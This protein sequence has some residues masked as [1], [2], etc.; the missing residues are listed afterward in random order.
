[1]WRRTRQRTPK[2]FQIICNRFAVY[3]AT[4]LFCT[5][6]PSTAAEPLNIVSIVTDDQAQW[7]LGCYGNTECRTPQMDRIAREGA[8][9]LNAF[10]CTPVCS[11]SRASFLTGRYGTQLGITDYLSAQ[12]ENAGV[13]LPANSVTWPKVLQRHGYVTGLFGKWHLGR[14]P[15][16]HPTKHGFHHFTG[17]LGGGVPPMDPTFEVNGKDQ[18]LKGDSSDL[19]TDHAL[20][21]LN[22][23]RQQPF[24][25]LVHYRAPH[26][27]YGPVLEQD[28]APFRDLDPKIPQH[29]GLNAQQV[30]NWTRVYYASIHSVD[31]NVGRLLAKL[32]ELKLNERTIV[33]FTSDHGY[34]IGHHG[35]H[36]KGNGWWVAGGVSGPKRPNLFDLSLRVPLLIRWPGVVRPGTEVRETISNIDTFAS[37]L[38]MLQVP[39]PDGWKQEGINFAPLLRGER[40]EP[41][42]ALFAQYDL[43]NLGLAYMRMIRTNDWKLVRHHRANG[44]DE[45]YDLK[46]DPGET[47]NLYG[48]AMHRQTRDELQSRLTS[49]M[50]SLD[51][52]LLK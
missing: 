29:P 33:L 51:D 17:F 49:W 24:A 30:K 34:M 46:N 35:I 48:N 9:F 20:E 52:P 8:K 10:T 31:R 22:G 21:F 25:L 19:L 16:F 2:G 27:P 45:L 6:S 5:A 47:R 37:V 26:T 40:Y 42:E 1:M 38:G 44:L 15:Q 4:L 12:E 41:R 13:G 28:A 39:A 18:K 14:Q 11:P 50:R 23:Q 3:L 36:T 32:D 7:A 43:H